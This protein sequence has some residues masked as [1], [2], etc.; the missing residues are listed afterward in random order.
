MLRFL[1]VFI[2]LWFGLNVAGQGVAI[3]KST[4]IVVIRGKS[5]YLHTVEPGQ[6][7]F[8]VCKAYG[9]N[10]EEVK[11][12][13]NK[14]DNNLALY[15]VL[16][17]PYV[18]PYVER[19]DKYYYHRVTKGETLYSISRQ[20]DIKP[21][22]LLR[23]NP[24]YAHNE[25]L[26][27]GAVVRIPLNEINS[28]LIPA[29]SQEETL[30]K[31]SVV[32]EEK[33][34]QEDWIEVGT[35]QFVISSDKAEE[36]KKQKADTTTWIEVEQQ[37]EG[38]PEHLSA[39]IIPS[40]PYV[41]IAILLPLSAKDYPRYLDSLS[42]G[43]PV[44]IS[45]RSEQ[46]ISFY[47]GILLAVD[48]LKNKGYKIDLH[49]FDTE[50]N[51]E[52]AYQLAETINQL[53]PDLILGPVYGSE[54][55]VLADNLQ[56]KNIPLVYPLSSRS[57]N[58]D[59]YP[60]FIQVNAS[61]NELVEEMSAWVAKRVLNANVVQIYLRGNDSS[62]GSEKQL[63]KDK[64]G[65]IDG[66][67]FFNWPV[68]EILLDSLRYRLLPDRE[69]ILILPAAK[70]TEVSKVLPL[71]STLTDGYQITVVGLPEWQTF[72][73]IDHETFYKLNTK[74]FT[75]SYVDY[76]SE[77]AVQLAA[78][79]RLYFHT[80][81][82][83][84]V[85]KAFDMGMFFIELAAQYR[86]RSLEALNYY[87]RDGSFSRFRFGQMKYGEG[88]ENQGFFIVNFASDYSLKIDFPER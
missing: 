56:N 45:S 34:E 12:M 55:K 68:D 83:S 28:S 86:D 73:S 6:T 22:R 10:L 3:Q 29:K 39:V 65:Q 53:Q 40:N 38:M 33:K 31:E 82:H 24:E 14:K 4:D 20:F 66:V 77:P 11:A 67:K 5:Y 57:E 74:L 61:L 52:K 8:S 23:Y 71:L 9:A 49:V 87:H 51:V 88:K 21:K 50:R 78:K 64:L 60:N 48:S 16:K 81:P 84:L 47:E 1:L 44:S 17:I 2:L 19:D 62:E 72:S 79:Y 36:Q 7:L 59:M 63:F 37:Q 27:V 54:Y 69:N 46:F 13:N 35:S 30:Q 76:A 15:E 75:Y 85:F 43:Q 32:K 18:E 26:S 70:E 80:E 25:P 41:K 58:F 42:L